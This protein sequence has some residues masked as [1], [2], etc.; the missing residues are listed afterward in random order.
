MRVL[1]L[2]WELPPRIAG[3]LGT[4][5]A[6]LSDALRGAGV[7]VDFLLPEGARQAPALERP[8]SPYGAA[9]A[10]ADPYAVPLER[11]VRDYALLARRT[12][13]SGRY[14]LIHAHDWTSFPGALAARRVSG[15]PL[16]CHVHSLESDRR[17]GAPDPWIEAVERDAL[18]RAERVLAVSAYSA[19]CV[20]EHH[21]VEARVVHNGVAP[22]GASSA[23]ESGADV[24]F[25]GRLTQQKDPGL[26]LDAAERI[27]PRHPDVHFVFAGE[28]ELFPSLIE[29]S[30]E[31][32]LARQVHFP[33]FLDPSERERA[34]ARA[35]LLVLPSRS[36]P[37]GLVALEAAARGVPVIVSTKSGVREV[38]THRL[39]VP[40]GDAPA[41][42]RAILRVLE[43]PDLAAELARGGRDDAAR[44]TWERCAHD[45]LAVYEELAA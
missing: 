6:G 7:E 30:A 20:R 37:F 35:G 25:L 17:P 39:D 29:R 40:P 12:V 21:G 22:P 16:V 31:R 4:A 36:E 42:A 43:E 44:A 33:G 23:A 3:G 8:P 10:S 5:C 19:L 14:D 18:R 26:L 11:A 1:M 2:G 27:C 28:G 34:F 24:L 15:L 45:T 38:L 9:R 13:L 41:L 32:G